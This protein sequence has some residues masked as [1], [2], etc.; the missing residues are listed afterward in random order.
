M[1]DL[2]MALT[3]HKSWTSARICSFPPTLS[4][5]CL[6]SFLPFHTFWTTAVTRTIIITNGDRSSD[7]LWL[8]DESEFRNHLVA[9]SKAASCLFVESCIFFPSNC[10]QSLPYLAWE[11]CQVLKS[12][13]PSATWVC[14]LKYPHCFQS[15][16]YFSV[17]SGLG[18]VPAYT[19][20]VECLSC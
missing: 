13:W 12:S 4:P 14:S 9:P 7:C 16:C 8:S 11:V 20:E 1:G 6:L 5:S 17:M 15:W 2:K 19:G 18:W 10:K 3:D